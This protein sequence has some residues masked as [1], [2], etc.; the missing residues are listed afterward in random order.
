MVEV[1]RPDAHPQDR[2]TRGK[3]AQDSQ[4]NNEGYNKQD[5]PARDVFLPELFVIFT[6]KVRHRL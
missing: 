1:H 6:H 2:T 3:A 5:D 4:Q